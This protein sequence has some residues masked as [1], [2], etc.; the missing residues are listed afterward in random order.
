[1]RALFSEGKIQE[2]VGELY[3]LLLDDEVLVEYRNLK[4]ALA[5][6]ADNQGIKNIILN[7]IPS[8]ALP[9]QLKM[10]VILAHEAYRN[11]KDD[12]IFQILETADAVV[13]HS[14][15]AY[16]ILSSGFEYPDINLLKEEVRTIISGNIK[17]LILN[18]VFNYASD[19]DYWRIIGNGKVAWDGHLNLYQENGDL[20]SSY[21]KM[22]ETLQT[23]LETISGIS[24]ERLADIVWKN[25]LLEMVGKKYDGNYVSK[26][27][28]ALLSDGY[29]S[30]D[31]AIVALSETAGKTFA[32][33][34]VFQHY[35]ARIVAND[36][37]F[38]EKYFGDPDML[39][40]WSDRN[41][42]VQYLNGVKATLL[43][44]SKSVFHI[45]PEDKAT[46]KWVLDDGRE[47]VIGERKD[48]TRYLQTDDHYLG[49]YNMA[50]PD[51]PLEHAVKDVFPYAIFGN[52]PDD[53]S[54]ANFLISM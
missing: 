22:R 44:D 45:S 19:D 51:N 10:A 31:E 37:A 35:S 42:P 40:K 39:K 25:T 18:A 1:M 5:L 11:G 26:A 21:Q 4:D 12:G 27:A 33:P 47:I 7:L 30:Y 9:D 16:D 20:L 50:N 2:Q 15:M 34:D 13:G 17:N 36:T 8:Y 52:T 43:P 28:E 46:Y 3:N 38:I 14:K 6:T 41:S 54:L 32:V 23:G 48:G 24:Y 53:S 49:T 29:M